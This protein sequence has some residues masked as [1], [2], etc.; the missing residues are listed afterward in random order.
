MRRARV[1]DL[2]HVRAELREQPAGERARPAAREVHDAQ[3]LEV[4][5]APAG[6]LAPNRRARRARLIRSRPLGQQGVALAEGGR[7]Q[8]DLQRAL[9]EPPRRPGQHAAR[10]LA[11]RVDFGPPVAAGL[12]VR[13][14][15]QVGRRRH[16]AEAQVEFAGPQENLTRGVRL[17]P[18]LHELVELAPVHQPRGHVG[19][20]WV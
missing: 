6:G 8:A 17:E 5:Q 13:V 3:A 14:V 18:R 2:H 19:E 7:L 12:E 10:G 1:L 15:E 4:A 9:R 11:V 20:E 16:L